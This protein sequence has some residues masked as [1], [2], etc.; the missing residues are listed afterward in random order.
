MTI[1]ID[2]L[3]VPCRHRLHLLSTSLRE[4]TLFLGRVFLKLI[5]LVGFCF[6]VTINT[7]FYC[8]LFTLLI[9]PEWIWNRFSRYDGKL[10]QEEVKENSDIVVDGDFEAEKVMICK[11]DDISE[12]ELDS[13]CMDGKERREAIDMVLEARPRVQTWLTCVT[14]SDREGIDVDT[15]EGENNRGLYLDTK[16]WSW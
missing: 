1:P 12:L 16:K 4:A 8:L 15:T 3:F 13:K 10:T 7:F 6:A 11:T 2:F 14:H 9:V 5:I